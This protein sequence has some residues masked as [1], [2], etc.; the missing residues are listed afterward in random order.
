MRGAGR[1]TAALALALA[2]PATAAWAEGASRVFLCENDAGRTRIEIIPVRIDDAG[3][4]EIEVVRDGT[5]FLGVTASDHGPFQ[6]GTATEHFA[7]LI[8]GTTD[9]GRLKAKLHH[10]TSS[11]TSTLTPYI[12]ETE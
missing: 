7:L 4:G 10:A 8:E 1:H 9:D 6:F 3:K 11:G 5:L 12:C 2:L